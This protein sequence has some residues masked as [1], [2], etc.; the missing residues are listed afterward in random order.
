MRIPFGKDTENS[1][2]GI[3]GSDTRIVSL[4]FLFVVFFCVK[5]I[6]KNRHGYF[7]IID[8]KKR[9]H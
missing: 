3:K 9:N 1:F 2:N 5:K 6:S 4:S 7:E 8:K